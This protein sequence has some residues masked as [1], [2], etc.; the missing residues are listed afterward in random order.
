MLIINNITLHVPQ[1][2]EP[3]WIELGEELNYKNE[4]TGKEWHF[5]KGFVSDGA[6]RPK[7]LRAFDRYILAFL[8]HDQDCVNAI[9][10][11]QRQTGNNDM[12]DNLRDQG[13]PLYRAAYHWLLVSFHSA[14]LKLIGK[15]K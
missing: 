11:E 12:F 1:S 15:L 6:T 7:P 2:S 14:G 13:C 5:P 9:G 3:V 8:A 10:W 4:T